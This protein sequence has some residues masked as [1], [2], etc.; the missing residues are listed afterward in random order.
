M[1][2]TAVTRSVLALAVTA[3]LGVTLLAAAPTAAAATPSGASEPAAERA[4]DAERRASC[5][6]RRK[7]CFGAISLNTRTGQFGWANDRRRR[8]VAVSAAQRSCK[9]RSEREGGFPGQCRRVGFARNECMA[10]AFRVNHEAIVEWASG[11]AYHAET[12]N[13]V[14]GAKARAR[15]KVRGPGEVRIAFWL[16][17]TRSR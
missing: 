9:T 4:G 13:G 1:R 15:A 17:T 12:R 6:W 11:Y 2:S 16:C 7:R 14:P 10:T 3:L 8:T 5:A